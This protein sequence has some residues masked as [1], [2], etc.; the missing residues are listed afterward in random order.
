MGSTRE[1]PRT[2]RNAEGFLTLRASPPASVAFGSS[3]FWAPA[4]RPGLPAQGVSLGSLLAARLPRGRA[5]IADSLDPSS[6][7]TCSGPPA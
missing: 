6:S 2:P 3:R 5:A 4:P 1:E 7:A